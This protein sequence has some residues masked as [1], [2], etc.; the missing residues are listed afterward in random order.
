MT[1]R[2]VWQ[3]KCDHCGKKK[4]T[5]QS[6]ARHELGC[7]RN[8]QRHCDLCETQWPRPE[9]LAALEGAREKL[10]NLLPGMGVSEY[11]DNGVIYPAYEAAA[12]EYANR[13]AYAAEGCPLCIMAAII[14]TKV[15]WTLPF[16]FPAALKEYKHE[17]ATRH[18]GL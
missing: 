18:D 1:K 7:V 4:Y 8:P 10:G 14:Q 9:L 13:V 3:Y 11:D 2:N 12:T 15:G 5:P 17:L 16:D 6:M